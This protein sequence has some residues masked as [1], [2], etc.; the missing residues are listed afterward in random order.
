M[1]ATASGRYVFYMRHSDGYTSIPMDMLFKTQVTFG[2]DADP[3]LENAQLHASEFGAFPQ[4]LL[5]VHREVFVP[6]HLPSTVPQVI[7]TRG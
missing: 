6:E 7:L 3:L 4:V 2:D 5:G 1:G